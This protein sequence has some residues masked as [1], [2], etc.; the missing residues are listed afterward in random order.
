M[1]SRQ[2][3]FRPS[4][5]LI[6]SFLLSLSG[7]FPPIA[8][9]DSADSYNTDIKLWDI[10]E[11]TT[12]HQKSSSSVNWKFAHPAPPTS[13][14]PPI[15]RQGLNW[16]EKKSQGQ[17]TV[18]EYGGGTLY[19]FNGGIKAIRA[20]V[21]DFGTCY[22][23]A[24][25]RGFELLKTFQ[26]PY[27]A[28]HNPY[29]TARIINELM[30]KTIKSEFQLRGVYPGHIAP[31]RP[32]TLMSKTPI[33]T[34]EDLRGKKIVSFMMMPG[35]EEVLGF[36]QVRMPFTEIYTALQQGLIDA[37]IWVE[38]GFVPFKIYEQAKY[39]TDINIAPLT[40]DT[41]LNKR[42]FD[43]LDLSLKEEIYNFQQR[44]G[45]A[46]VQ[47]AESFASDAQ[48]ILKAN[49]VTVINLS[50]YER[51][52]WKTAFQPVVTRSLDDCKE[53]GKDC[54]DLINQIESLAKKYAGLTDNELI[55]LAI[56]K[57][58]QGIIDF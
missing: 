36:A 48:A 57:P 58:V 14:L 42:S 56:E 46:I 15:W 41:C 30:A 29:L 27:V 54:V 10:A 37:V 22:T 40:V 2:S 52:R 21:A 1:S 53:E 7:V 39:Y 13:Q 4:L 45:I 47:K 11:G 51:G 55:R 19:G 8:S 24:E 9:A 32:L 26:V 34:P 5:R 31:V 50:D 38:S 43:R 35:A 20:G 12:A 44:M 3:T 17:I 28:P 25:K 23:I 33:K 18:K 49:G 6:A 16:L